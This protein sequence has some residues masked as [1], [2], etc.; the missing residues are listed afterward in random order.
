MP[1]LQK[2]PFPQCRYKKAEAGFLLTP[3]RLER[4]PRLLTAPRYSQGGVRLA[5]LGASLWNLALAF[6]TFKHNWFLSKHKCAVTFWDVM[7]ARS[8]R[9]P[10]IQL[11]HF[12]C[13]AGT[14]QEKKQG[15][16][17]IPFLS[18]VLQGSREGISLSFPSFPVITLHQRSTFEDSFLL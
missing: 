10:P 7:P 15:P 8:C 12:L 4:V 3:T 5:S 6:I 14:C 18:L 11:K 1:E 17:D 13:R 2:R 16:G 9:V